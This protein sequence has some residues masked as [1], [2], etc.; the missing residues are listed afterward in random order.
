MGCDWKF[1]SMRT[2]DFCGQCGGDNS[3]CNI[4]DGKIEFSTFKN[5]D[6]EPV[7][8]LPRGAVSAKI[9]EHAWNHNLNYLA[10][11]DLDGLI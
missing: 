1:D 6:Y 11:R 3:S 10:I 9:S 7:L 2:I 5:G 8:I 4:L